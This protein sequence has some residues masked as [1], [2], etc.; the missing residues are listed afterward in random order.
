MIFSFF[1]YMLGEN[2]FVY[3][4]KFLPFNM[5]SISSIQKHPQKLNRMLVFYK[6]L[7]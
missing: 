5:N 2:K 4:D 6:Y 3:S 1:L 7:L